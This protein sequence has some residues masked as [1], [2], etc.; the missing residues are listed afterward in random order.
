MS[1]SIILIYGIWIFKMG[2]GAAIGTI[3][4][5]IVMLVFYALS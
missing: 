1:S 3:V 4:F 2:I 5:L